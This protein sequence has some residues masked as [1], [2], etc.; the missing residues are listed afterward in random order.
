MAGTKRKPVKKTT[1]KATRKAAPRSSR[2]TATRKTSAAKQAHVSNILSQLKTK[3]AELKK[4]QKR[5]TGFIIKLLAIILIG[6]AVFLLAKKYRS[7]FVAGTVNNH[8]ITRWELNKKLQDSYG[9]TAFDEMVSEY[10]LKDAAKKNG[11]TVSQNEIDE[12]V[13]S[14]AAQYGGKDQLMQMAQSA[15]INTD[16]QLNQFFEMQLIVQK[17]EDKL[18]KV[19][20]TDDEIQKYYDDNKDYLGNKKLDEV[21]DQ[22]KQQLTSQKLSDQFSQWFSDLRQKANI[23]D[24]LTN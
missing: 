21:R 9:K 23:Q 20:I 8:P 15:G 19:S 10:L 16:S 7:F 17:L 1:Q 18:F 5:S 14:A 12:K 11:I 22:I 2:R 24:Y 4:S 6:S 3:K 13:A